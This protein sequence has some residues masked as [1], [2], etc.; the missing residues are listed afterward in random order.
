VADRQVL[1]ALGGRAKAAPFVVVL[2]GQRRLA[3]VRITV[4]AYGKV[5]ARELAVDY[6]EQGKAVKVS[7]PK[8]AEV[9]PATA[10]VYNLLNN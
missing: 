4:P 2:D 10:A 9:A 3:S 1:A 7:V 8:S 6:A 5:A